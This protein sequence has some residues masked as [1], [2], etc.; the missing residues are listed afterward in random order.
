MNIKTT[1][2]ILTISTACATA[3]PRPIIRGTVGGTYSEPSIPGWAMEINALGMV[4]LAETS[5]DRRSTYW[6]GPVDSVDGARMLVD[7]VLTDEDQ[8]YSTATLEGDPCGEGWDDR[9]YV[10]KTE[11]NDCIRAHGLTPSDF[12]ADWGSK[13]HPDSVDVSNWIY[14]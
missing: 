11:I 1:F 3:Q 12:W 4:R 8:D 13:D 7:A 6:I 9:A 2:T 5:G 14:R 10:S